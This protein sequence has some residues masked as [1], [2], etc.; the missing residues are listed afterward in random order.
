MELENFGRAYFYAMKNYIVEENDKYIIHGSSFK[1][2][3]AAKVVD[4]AINLAIQH[5]FNGLPKDEVLTTALNFKNLP[6]EYF[7]ER[8]KLS[9]EPREYDDA[10]DMRLCLAK[11]M[12]MKTGQIAAKGTQINYVVAK[13]SLP[14]PELRPYYKING[15]NY[16]FTK[17]IDD[18]KQLDF[19]YYEELI[20]K[21]LD[22]F[23]IKKNLQLNLFG[24]DFNSA[25]TK[26]KKLDIVPTDN[27]ENNIDDV[28]I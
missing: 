4:K 21:A 19:T 26:A 3:R 1:A 12:E 9:K 14:F 7:E 16:T 27:L 13:R 8:V 25:P 6:L 23:G 18:T 24:D 2:S 10:Y 17:W 20:L 28:N 22:K 11:Q 15:K 5:V